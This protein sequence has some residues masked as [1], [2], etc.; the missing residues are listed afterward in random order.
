MSWKDSFYEALRNPEIRRRISEF[1]AKRDAVKED[2]DT[3][4]RWEGDDMIIEFKRNGRW[5]FF[6][7]LLFNFAAEIGQYMRDI[8]ERRSK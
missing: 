7:F 3:H 1:R 4:I 6:D 5:Y 8:D 2:K